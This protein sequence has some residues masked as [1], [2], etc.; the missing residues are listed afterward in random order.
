[1]KKLIDL[2]AKSSPKSAFLTKNVKKKKKL[3][4]ELS[5]ARRRRRQNGRDPR[6][7]GSPACVI[8]SFFGFFILKALSL[9]QV[10]CFPRL[11]CRVCLC[12]LWGLRS[13]TFCKHLL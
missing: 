10:V 9:D 13:D 12:D 2:L 1:M 7:S 5:Q 11:G 4:T 3:T 8:F 6:F